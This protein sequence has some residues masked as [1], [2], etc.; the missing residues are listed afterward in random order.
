M[1]LKNKKSAITFLCMLGILS[2]SSQ[3]FASQPVD[4]S[5]SY[6]NSHDAIDWDYDE[7]SIKVK[8]SDTEPNNWTGTNNT[9]TLF[10]AEHGKYTGIRLLLEGISDETE[11]DLI[12]TTDEL[13]PGDL[14]AEPSTAYAC[15]MI[16]KDGL[17][18]DKVKDSIQHIIWMSRQWNNDSTVLEADSREYDP[19][20]GDSRTSK[21]VDS[22]LEDRAKQY[23]DVYYNIYKKIQ[24]NEMFKTTTTEKDLKIL[25]DEDKGTYTV[26][27]Y[28]LEINA[29]DVDEDSKKTLYNELIGSNQGYTV[30]NAFAKLK[31]IT[32]IN[33]NDIKFI[34]TDGTE[35]KFPNFVDSD[36]FYIQFKPND[37]GAIT[38]VGTPVIKIDYLSNPKEIVN[39]YTIKGLAYNVEFK[40]SNSSIDENSIGAPSDVASTKTIAYKTDENGNNI[41]DEDG[42]DI[43]ECV[44]CAKQTG[45][46]KLILNF[47]LHADKYDYANHRYYPKE[48]NITVESEVT[49]K[50]YRTVS[51]DRINGKTYSA[52]SFDGTFDESENFWIDT[53]KYTNGEGDTIA[54]YMQEIDKIT[55]QTPS[56]TDWTQF[57]VTLPGKNIDEVL[58]GNVWVDAMGTKSGNL[59]GIFN[60]TDTDTANKENPYAGMQVQLFES[61]GNLVSTTITDSNGQYKFTGLNPL[62]K[63]FVRFIYNGEIYQSTYYKN[64]LTGG[65]SNAKDVDREAFNNKF[66]KID[67]TAENYKTDS[68]HKSYALE[69]KLM[70]KNEEYIANGQDKD[71]N[72]KA[73][74]YEDAW[75]QFVQYTIDD[76]GYGTAYDSLAPWLKQKGVGNQ[77]ITDVIQFI[78]DCMITATT[79]VVDPLAK[80]TTTVNVLY[81]VYD[82]FVLED[83][84]NP[85]SDK[86]TIQLGKKYTY[87]YLYT[88][89]SD[90]SRY[91]DYGITRRKTADLGIN[92]DV[93]KAT[94]IVNGKTHTY[95]YNQKDVNIKDDGSWD[96]TVRASDELYNGSYTY[97]REIRKSE[98]LYTESSIKYK[99]NSVGTDSSKDLQVY[100]TYRIVVKNKG[101]VDTSVNEIVDYY[102]ADQYEFDGTL[103]SD[104]T[105]AQTVYNSYDSNE[106]VTGSYIN[107]YVGN[108]ESENINQDKT[109][110]T[111]IVSSKTSF[112]DREAS[113]TLTNWQY[114]YSSLYLTGLKADNGN[115]SLKPGQFAYAYV[116]FKV[117][118]DATTGKVKLDQDLENGNQTVGK[119]NIAEINGYSTHYTNGDTIPNYL[120]SANNET[121]NTDV[122]SK[123]AGIIDQNSNAGSLTTVDLNENGDIRT[124][125]KDPKNEVKNRI[126]DDTDKAPNIKVI[127]ETTNTDYNRTFNG[128]TYEDERT[129]NYKNSLTGNGTYEEK[130]AN[131]N[132]ETKISGVTVQLVEL[133]QKVDNH[134]IFLGT[135]SG[136]YVWSSMTYD[137]KTKQ[138]TTDD[139]RYYSGNGKAKVIL[140]GSGILKVDTYDIGDGEYAYTS[141]PT[142]DFF[143]RFTYGDTDQ[144]VLTNTD[145]DVNKL[146]ET[147]GLN[148]KSYNGQDYKSTV[149]QSGISQGGSYNGINAYTDTENQNYTNLDGTINKGTDKT[150]MYYYDIDASSKIAGASD[151]K[152]VYCYR[153][154]ANDYSK[155]IINNKAE[156]L[157]SF[158]KIGTYQY[159][160]G[161]GTADIAKQKD[162]QRTMVDN[163][164]YN[165]KMVSQTG[166]INTEVEYNRNSTAVPKS[167]NEKSYMTY[168][169]KDI[170][171][172]LTERAEAGIKLT[173]EVSNVKVVLANN[174]TLFDTNQSV[175]N[176]YYSKHTGH[177]TGY[178]NYRMITPVV[179][180]SN[181]S[182]TPELIQTY[183]DDEL[184]EGSTLRITYKISAKNVGEIDYLDKQFYYTGITKNASEDNMSKTNTN[185]IVDYVSNMIKYD[186][187]YQDANASWDIKTTKDLTKSTN[188]SGT[189]MT[190]DES[191]MK[192][193][194]INRKYYQ[195]LSTYNTILT[196]GKLSTDLVPEC[197]NKDKC[198]ATTTLVVSTLLSSNNS[199]DNLVYNNLSEVIKTSNSQGRRL[200]YSIAGNQEMS[201]QSLGN[202]AK[203]SAEGVYT[204]IDLMTPSEIDADSAQKLVILPPTGENKNFVST[205]IAMIIA[206]GLIIATIVI[207]RKRV[208]K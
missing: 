131:R 141:I 100:V 105:Y 162:N 89:S 36:D 20:K 55:F 69:S 171:L 93:Y 189:T 140:T 178:S 87:T 175:N 153:D 190:I 119:R 29:N 108:K 205:I 152:D 54:D 170:D 187:S 78:K 186:K 96:V 120:G 14:N 204:T 161:D 16:Q 157:D 107:S 206:A 25:V 191:K 65:Y 52:W 111:L 202:N 121:I 73:L 97:S 124:D 18:Y 92:K 159:K 99:N 180:K 38:N 193:D 148:A 139:S 71:G 168:I 197:A 177:T 4:G 42:N 179:S 35:I 91:V 135:Y 192:D 115:D 149:Y 184:M 127:I 37:D 77:E 167:E 118:N 165:T 172:G 34:S 126:E 156:I 188:I 136:E 47:V 112:A 158:E 44:Y 39:E 88:K 50:V 76:K 22:N 46:A 82:Q 203:T 6:Y 163:L 182:E 194:L 151:A 98:Y 28:K 146:L 26:G 11:S 147:K 66:V 207:I 103:Q 19:E 137:T 164:T 110:T 133:V 81:P 183:I 7:D 130:D 128:Y 198:S 30:A 64:N 199:A 113:K 79:N 24:N 27:P 117:K 67:S 154:K 43:I 195:N 9:N 59:N 102:D 155:E 12:L 134:G 201:D 57:G 75:N 90:Q 138:W 122:S 132:A 144:T 48:W 53:T 10:C 62:K 208:I 94:V 40:N 51:Y 145:S 2:F 83:L 70:Q 109:K 84:N 85:P 106:N 174:Q 41:K 60:V 31:S 196:S 176:M 13:K 80:T 33:G 129:N 45:N 143:I 101:E 173:K 185:A 17:N 68:W 123:S 142:G 116:T 61:T 114:N 169:V 32:G 21:N 104:G 56:D 3:I 166:I 95:T 15:H 181:T 5:K 63:Y 160:N 86:A 125:P 1:K 150:S 58:G 200:E 8:Y 49:E 23:G 74:T 72:V